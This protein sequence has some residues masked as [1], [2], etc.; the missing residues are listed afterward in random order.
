MAQPAVDIRYTPPGP[1]TKW[2]TSLVPVPIGTAC[3]TNHAGPI[4]SSRLPTSISP[5]APTY[6][7]HASSCSFTPL[8][9]INGGLRDSASACTPAGTS[10]RRHTLRRALEF[11]R[12][13]C[14]AE[15]P[16]LN[17]S[18]TSAPDATE[19]WAS[20]AP[21]RGQASPHRTP[22]RRQPT[23]QTTSGW[24][25]KSDADRR[26]VCAKCG[27]ESMPWGQVGVWVPEHPSP[28][29]RAERV[30]PAVVSHN[31]PFCPQH[32]QRPGLF[33]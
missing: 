27:Q 16:S 29:E 12:N 3:R 6:H 20:R 22:G 4:D 13:P 14:A 32:S 1:M 18:P 17:S 9:D 31:R 28:P 5:R 8:G 26:R 7:D 15:H 30:V 33:G 24:V 19:V 10:P 23:C 25:T 2:S 11:Q 21:Q